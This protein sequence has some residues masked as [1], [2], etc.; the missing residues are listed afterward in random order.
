MKNATA[1]RPARRSALLGRDVDILHGPIVGGTVAFAIPMILQNM[2]A[3]LYNAADI[4][5]VGNMSDKVAVAS[6]GATTTIIGLLVNLFIA[7]NAGYGVILTRALGQNDDERIKRVVKTGYTF[8]LILG[9]AITVIGMVFARP[10]LRLTDCPDDVIDGATLYLRIYMLGVP[11]ITFTNFNGGI[12]RLRGDSTRPFIYSA[13]SGAA[14]VVLNIVLVL[15]TGHAVV[16][17]AVATVI[18]TYISAVLYFIRLV[19]IDGACRLKPLDFGINGDVFIK[20]LRYG[21]P[22]MV[23]S[24]TY[25]VANIQI[26]SA[27]NSFEAAGISGNTAAITIEAFAFAV[28]NTLMSVVATFVGQSIGAGD[29]KRVFK[30][31]KCSYLLWGGVS[32]VTGTLVLVFGKSLIGLIIP[33]EV[34]AIAFGAIRL[35]YIGIA[36]FMHGLININSGSMQAFGKTAFQMIV[37]LIG[38]CGFRMIWMSVIYPL[39]PMPDTLYMCFPISYALIT[40]VGILFVSYLI[41]K[42]KRGEDFAI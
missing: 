10:M 14:N 38:V 17:V 3:N 30:I 39:N 35:K 2:L 15:I 31:L 32:L 1:E 33:G 7:I 34:E 26:Q 5:V 23:S 12:I 8:S 24:A 36:I 25:S 27:I 21:V 28:T 6:V 29:R 22:A 37:N 20:I 19:R 16:S 18:S 41:R 42:Y 9:L 40:T 4:A 13:I 11:A